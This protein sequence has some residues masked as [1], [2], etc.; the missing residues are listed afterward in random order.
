MS[1]DHPIDRITAHFVVL[2]DGT[3]FYTHDVEFIL[4]SVSGR[5][6][7]DIEFAGSFS[8]SREPPARSAARLR[9]KAIRTGRELVRVLKT[10]IP[11][12][13][14]IHPHGQLQR[15]DN[16]GWCGGTT[17]NRCGKL[18]SCPG[19]DIWVN[20]GEWAVRQLRLTSATPLR[21]Y[22]NNGI[23]DRQS[24]PRYNQRIP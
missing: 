13:T 5:Y 12:I 3:V 11:S 21:G 19:P 15:R 18:Y 2:N 14:H 9:P 1:S 17:G 23:H 8:T 10:S 22:Q 20:V 16:Q 6:G 4:A 24:N 7:I